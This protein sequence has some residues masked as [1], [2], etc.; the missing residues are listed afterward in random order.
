MRTQK[1]IK[2]MRILNEIASKYRYEIYW[3][4]EDNCWLGK[5]GEFNLLMAHSEDGPRCAL[6]EIMSL[7][8]DCVSDMHKNNEII[9]I[10][11][12]F[13]FNEKDKNAG[14]VEYFKNK[15]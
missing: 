5:V 7:V 9:P 11:K 10:P 12:C 4:E 13:I 3:S 6:M 15:K 14:A 8:E 1:K 2:E